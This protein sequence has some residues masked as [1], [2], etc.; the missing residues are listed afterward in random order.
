MTRIVTTVRIRRPI[1]EVFAFATTPMNWPAWHPASI[2][3]EGGDHPCRVGEEAVEE[4]V[5][6]GR[7]GCATWR[8][9]HRDAPHRWRI[10]TETPEARAAVEYRL[11]ADETDTLFERDLSYEV[12]GAWLAVLDALV[13]RRRMERE[14]RQALQ[15]LKAVL[16]T[17]APQGSGRRPEAAAAP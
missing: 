1:D 10:E 2:S 8:V 16:E 9:T 13:L 12:S 4:F 14:S 5:A 3:V 6:A 17:P 7:H 11:R 15:N